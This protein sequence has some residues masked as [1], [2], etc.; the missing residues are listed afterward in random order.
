MTRLCNQVPAGGTRPVIGSDRRG[1]CLPGCRSAEGVDVRPLEGLLLLVNLLSFVELMRRA[2]EDP[3][4]I[5]YAPPAGTLTAASQALFEGSRWQMYPAYALCGLFGVSWLWRRAR[6]RAKACA[7]SR[8]AGRAL[9]GR[10]IRT[11]STTAATLTRILERTH[12]ITRASCDRAVDNVRK[13]RPSGCGRR[14]LRRRPLLQ[15]SLHRCR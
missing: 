9:C 12:S 13:T 4:W 8:A 1:C 15:R 14:R 10:V 11:A 6:R 7:A 3:R 5:G 2:P